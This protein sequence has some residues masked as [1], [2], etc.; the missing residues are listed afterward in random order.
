MP[1]P[2]LQ[3][4]HATHALPAWLPAAGDPNLTLLYD[5]TAH[6]VAA[7]LLGLSYVFS[8][9]LVLTTLLVSMMTNTLQKAST[10]WRKGSR[11]EAMQGCLSIPCDITCTYAPFCW[12]VGWCQPPGRRG[13]TPGPLRRRPAIP[14]PPRQVTR[15]AEARQQRSKALAIDEL[16]STV[17]RCTAT[18]RLLC[19]S[20]G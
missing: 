6:P 7:S 20:P 15:D 4:T 3:P 12:P 2:C 14:L 19:T 5:G 11:C 8:L 16:E 13:S 18:S 17:P 10:A 1:W 9:T